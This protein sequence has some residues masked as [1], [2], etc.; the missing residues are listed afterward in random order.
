ML[1]AGSS[2]AAGDMNIS[3][4]PLFELRFTHF[5]VLTLPTHQG[6]SI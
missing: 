2:S 5:L 4:N 1:L 3:E 6:R